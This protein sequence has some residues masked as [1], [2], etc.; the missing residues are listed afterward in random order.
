MSNTSSPPPNA[1]TRAPG[2]EPMVESEPPRRMETHTL[3]RKR[4]ASGEDS[5][6][7]PTAAVPVEPVPST[8]AGEKIVN[9]LDEPERLKETVGYQGW[10]IRELRRQV[11]NLESTL[12]SEDRAREMLG[13][14]VND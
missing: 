8:E 9:P 12:R 3:S 11:R 13:K 4:N 1:P 10:L 6:S 5:S 2:K 14:E 7:R